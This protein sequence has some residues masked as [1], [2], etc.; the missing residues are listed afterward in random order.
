MQVTRIITQSQL[1]AC[2]GDV[3]DGQIFLFH[4]ESI[5]SGG[6]PAQPITVTLVANN[7][8]MDSQS[9]RRQQL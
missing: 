4:H 1:A 5:A 3:R 8:G 9:L 6:Q 2:G 7:Q